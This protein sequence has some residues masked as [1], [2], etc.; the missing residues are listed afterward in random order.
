MKAPLSLSSQRRI[1]NENSPVTGRDC[2]LISSSKTPIPI[3]SI[4]KI[5]PE[6][7]RDQREKAARKAKLAAAL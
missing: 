1:G 6:Y 4:E 7:V 2:A 3:I 5:D